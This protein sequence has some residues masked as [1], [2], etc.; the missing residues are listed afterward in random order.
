MDAYCSLIYDAR[1]E[2][3]DN[4]KAKINQINK[5]FLTDDYK[6]VEKKAKLFDFLVKRLK[7]IEDELV[8]E[9]QKVQIK[10]GGEL[11]FIEKWQRNQMAFKENKK[12]MFN[13]Q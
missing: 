6:E 3:I 8:I 7:D 5:D 12:S 9:E 10:G 11:S 1:R 2:Y 4:L 13:E